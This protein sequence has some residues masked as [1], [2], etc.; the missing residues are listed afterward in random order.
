MVELGNGP[1]LVLVP[2]IPGPWQYVRLAVE[3][4]AV[5][6]RVLTFSLGP[7]CSIESDVARI[8]TALD[9]RRIDRAVV[10]GIS[11]G[12]LVALHFAA[13]CP[14][15]TRALVL[16]STPGPGMKLRP[17]HRFYARWPYVFGPLFVAET[18]FRMRREVASALPHRSDRRAFQWAQ[19]KAFL[20]AGVS[21]SQI[22]RRALRIEDGDIG[23]DCRRVTAP[24]LVVTGDPD[25]DW[26]VPVS[27]T[28]GYLSLI[29][30]ARHAVLE[31]T[32]HLGTITQPRLFAAAIERFLNDAESRRHEVA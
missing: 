11:F 23:A 9:E 17:R 20:T 10:C 8:A 3:S 1:A 13:T 7:E 26:V 32:G 14:D 4:L 30:G 24:T 27:D 28:A 2:G 21:L 15:R 29:A 12:G 6:F 19:L 18:P 5:S 22:A 31:G 25:L 16:A